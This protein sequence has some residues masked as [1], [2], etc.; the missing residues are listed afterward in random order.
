MCKIHKFTNNF[1]FFSVISFTLVYW[2]LFRK[3][4]TTNTHNVCFGLQWHRT[5][6][7][8]TGT[9]KQHDPLMDPNCTHVNAQCFKKCGVELFAI[10]LTVNWFWKG[11]HC[12]KQQ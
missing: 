5:L 3:C 4:C 12:W 8:S 6:V 1:I 10:T 7:E 9:A 2:Q 11:F